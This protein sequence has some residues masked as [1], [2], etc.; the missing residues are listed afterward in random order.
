MKL[1]RETRINVCQNGYA[2][3]S[4]EVM[5]RFT[6]ALLAVLLV[7]ALLFAQ[8]PDVVRGCVVVDPY[9][10]LLPAAPSPHDPRHFDSRDRYDSSRRFLLWSDDD[11]LDEIKLHEGDEIEVTGQINP[12]PPE[13]LVT[14]PHLRPPDGGF[15]GQPPGGAFPGVSRPGNPGVSASART[16]LDPPPGEDVIVVEKFKVIRPGCRPLRQF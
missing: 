4:T 9:V 7:P 3:V 16:S 13:S 1:A 5:M 15:P 2:S 11:L 12:P 6:L 14:P 8:R 10:L